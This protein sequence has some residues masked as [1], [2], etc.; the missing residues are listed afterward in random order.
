MLLPVLCEHLLVVLPVLE[1]VLWHVNLHTLLPV[2][3]PVPPLGWPIAIAVIPGSWDTST[4]VL[5][6]PAPIPTCK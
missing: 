4:A 2:F 3:L 5:Q 6:T 1:P